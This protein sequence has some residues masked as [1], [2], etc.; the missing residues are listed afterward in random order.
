VY[1]IELK[2]SVPLTAQILPSSVFPGIWQGKQKGK[3]LEKKMA[4][5]Y[6]TAD[7]EKQLTRFK[8]VAPNSNLAHGELKDNDR[9]FHILRDGKII[10]CF[11]HIKS[12]GGKLF[13]FH[14]SHLTRS[15]EEVLLDNLKDKDIEDAIKGP[16]KK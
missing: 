13:V 9:Y 12:R 2:N 5:K 8:N 3:T 16:W 11:T 4:M 1:K 15:N 14:N 10:G 7:A 6:S